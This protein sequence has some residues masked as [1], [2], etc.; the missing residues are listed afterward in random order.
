MFENSLQG[1]VLRVCLTQTHVRLHLFNLIS[2]VSREY[3]WLLCRQVRACRATG[4]YCLYKYL[5]HPMCSINSSYIFIYKLEKSELNKMINHLNLIIWTNHYGWLTENSNFFLL[6]LLQ[7][8]ANMNIHY[9]TTRS[10]L[11]YLYR[12]RA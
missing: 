1:R 4:P 9:L 6:V 8:I 7:G 5:A 12:R 10:H 3:K 2:I 11:R